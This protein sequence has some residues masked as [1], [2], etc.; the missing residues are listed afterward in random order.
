MPVTETPS[1]EAKQFRDGIDI[2]AVDGAVQLLYDIPAIQVEHVRHEEPVINTGFWR[3]VGV[4]H[5]NFV[6][7]S[8]TDELAAASRQDPEAFRRPCWASRHARWPCWTSR[9]RKPD[10]GNHCRAATGVGWPFSTAGGAPTWRRSPK[11]R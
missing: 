7:E 4:I 9:R 11:W 8:F 10:G 2:D 1:P 5:N 6:I 3:G